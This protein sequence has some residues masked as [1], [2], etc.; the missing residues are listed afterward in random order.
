MLK[1]IG[2]LGN[3]AA[4]TE[5]G[6][7]P[8][9]WNA[10]GSRN[11]W[12][13]D[14]QADP[15]LGL[16]FWE[17]FKSAGIQAA[18][19]SAGNFV[20]DKAWYQYGDTAG[21]ITDSGI[22]G[23]AINLAAGT[24]DNAGMAIGSLVNAFKLI[25]STGAYQGRMIFETRVNLSAATLA[26]SKA[27]AFIGLVDGSGTP[28]AAMPITA[29]DGVLSTSPGLIGFH[30]RG[31]TTGATDWQFV[32]QIAGGT[33]VYATGLTDLVTTVTG[34]APVGGTFYKLGFD[35]NP[36]AEAVMISTA[37]TGQTAGVLARP[38]ITVY[39]NGM[40]CV[41]FL[42]STNVAGAAFPQT[43]M[44]PTIAFRMANTT[45]AMSMDVD[46]IGVIQELLA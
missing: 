28:A 5:R 36:F 14:F 43:F 7:S 20:A 30:K 15:R 39:I 21:T 44:A 16:V 34:A 35:F 29:T 41:S 4:D 42:T 22:Q 17:D 6:P 1:S 12:V 10:P 26:N 13:P 11:G 8:A 38:I 33:A 31:G 45:A 19:G 23:G 3:T 2:V 27:D 9:L 24:T 32:Y 40:K 37:S 46:W 18:T 25:T